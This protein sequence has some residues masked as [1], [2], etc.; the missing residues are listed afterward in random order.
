MPLLLHHWAEIVGLW[1]EVTKQADDD[2][3][4]ALLE[5]VL[6]VVPSSI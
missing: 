6:P 2:V 1:I 5:Y 4:R 3:L